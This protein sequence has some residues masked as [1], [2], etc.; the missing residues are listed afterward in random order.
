[1][2]YRWTDEDLRDL[3]IRPIE[4]AETIPARWFTSPELLKDESEHILAA[5]WQYVGH[6]SQIPNPG[7]YLVDQILGRPVLIVRSQ[8]NEI[9]CFANVCRHRGGPLA[10]QSGTTRILR[11]KYHAWTYN[12]DGGLVGTPKFEGVQ[13]FNK[14]EC[15]L[16]KYRLEQYE[17]LM[18]V[19]FS[20][21]AD[22]LL[23]YLSGIQEKIAPIDLKQMRFHSRVVYPV[24]ANWKV[25]ID[26]Y[27]EGYHILPVHP[28]LSKILDISHYK[29]EIDGHR[30][31]QTG[32]LAGEDNP[33]HTS[34]NAYYYYVFPNLMLN[35]L[36]GRLQMNSIMPVDATNCLT[37][38]DFFFS[39]VDELRRHERARDDLAV[40]DL[41]QMEDIGICE[42]VQR[43]L[44]SGAYNK[45]RI[46]V[47]EEL[48]VWAFQNSL[49]H[50]YRGLVEKQQS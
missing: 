38:F 36:P 8:S 30:V 13:N 19:N 20:G 23:T 41:V 34:G 50:A 31:L 4:F 15:S 14:S 47:R 22:S 48:G 49:R 26:N 45:G 3:E 43:G 25:Y 40:S 46:C 12:L 27:M 42:L 16:P 17:G 18:F 29:T 39:E 10:D 11:C 7:D 37:V 24:K 2:N 6:V 44:S 33:Y 28:E 21:T 9:H 35:I 32:P 1:M 5:G